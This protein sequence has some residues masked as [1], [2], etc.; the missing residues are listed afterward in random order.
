MIK[1]EA[2]LVVKITVSS[3]CHGRVVTSWEL[4]NCKGSLRFRGVHNCRLKLWY[5][6]TQYGKVIY[7]DNKT[8]WIAIA[9]VRKSPIT[10][11]SIRKNI[12]K[13]YLFMSDKQLNPFGLHYF[14][15]SI[16]EPKLADDKWQWA[17]SRR[18]LY[19]A[20]SKIEI[21][22]AKTKFQ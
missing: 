19:L 2:S 12:S 4:L 18:S 3:S 10:Q 14:L 9:I 22:K 7:G 8:L 16:H 17:P 6:R 15:L 1:K 20:G 5:I 11:P 21:W 13:T